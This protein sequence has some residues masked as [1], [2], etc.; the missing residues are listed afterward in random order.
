MRAIDEVMSVQK[1][2]IKTYARCGEMRPDIAEKITRCSASVPDA[3][4][5][6]LP[7]KY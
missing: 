4:S 5:S 6:I 2:R 3:S 1:G 7:S